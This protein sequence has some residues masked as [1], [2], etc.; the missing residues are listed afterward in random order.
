MRKVY[1]STSL[2]DCSFRKSILESHGIRCLI[3]NELLSPLAGGIPA[4]EVLPELWIIDEERFE[5]ALKLLDIECQNGGSSAES[6]Q[7]GAT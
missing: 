7:G 4:P 1:T 2:V 5:E 3:R 6:E